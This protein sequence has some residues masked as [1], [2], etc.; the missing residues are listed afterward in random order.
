MKCHFFRD[1]KEV[2]GSRWTDENIDGNFK[3][4][5]RTWL[6]TQLDKG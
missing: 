3:P 6:D 4:R 2:P 5:L 1:G